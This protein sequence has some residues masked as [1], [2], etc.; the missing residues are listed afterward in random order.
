MHYYKFTFF[1]LTKFESAQEI[2]E[3]IAHAQRHPL[4]ASRIR[5]LNFGQSLLHPYSVYVSRKS[6]AEFVQAR[7]RYSVL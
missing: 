4:I 2:L 7:R 6:S 5:N 1:S 3:L